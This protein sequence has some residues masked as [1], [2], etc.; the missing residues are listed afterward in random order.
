MRHYEPA[1]VLIGLLPRRTIAEIRCGLPQVDNARGGAGARRDARSASPRSPS[2]VAGISHVAAFRTVAPPSAQPAQPGQRVRD[3]SG[4]GPAV[5]EGGIDLPK[6]GATLRSGARGQRGV[7]GSGATGSYAPPRPLSN[8]GWR[9]RTT[10]CR[11]RSRR[12]SVRLLCVTKTDLFVTHWPFPQK[13]VWK[14]S[15]P[16][17]AVFGGFRK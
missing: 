10:R 16:P 2:H 9:L 14:T 8:H 17:T 13:A 15:L 11:D 7:G 3:Q 4:D 5:L 6:H 1:S 12:R